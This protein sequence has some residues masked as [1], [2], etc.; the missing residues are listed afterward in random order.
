MKRKP[1][2]KDAFHATCS[3]PCWQ[4]AVYDRLLSKIYF[5]PSKFPLL[6]IACCGTRAATFSGFGKSLSEISPLSLASYIQ[7][8][9]SYFTYKAMTEHKTSL[10]IRI[11]D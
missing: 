11:S 7:F 8:E 4:T 6:P 3:L 10:T 1:K 2:W 5:Y 9:R